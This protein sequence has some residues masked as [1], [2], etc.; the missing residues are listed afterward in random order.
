MRVALL[1]WLM[2]CAAAR[3]EQPAGSRKPLTFNLGPVVLRPSGFFD[4]IAE[5]RSATTPDTISTNFGAIPLRATPGETL[6][7]PGHS[8]L[9]LKAETGLAGGTL[10]GY[11]EADFLDKAGYQCYRSRQY[12]GEYSRSGWRVLAGQAW[13]LLR[14]NRKG[15]STESGLLNTQAVDP[16]YHVGLAGVRKPQVRITRAM[17]N[18][19]AALAYEYRQGGDVLLKL[20]RDSRLMHLEAVGLGGHHGRKGASLAAVAHAGPRVDLV[21]QQLWSQGGG[22]DVLGCLPRGVHA[23]ATI[24]GVEARV[25]PTLEVF[26]YGGLVYGTRSAGNRTVRQWSAGFRQKLFTQAGYGAAYLMGQYS[27]LDRALW[28]GPRG[29]MNFAMLAFRY[30]M[31]AQ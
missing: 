29:N 12:W 30:Y 23:H 19:A 18:W 11:F 1:L 28:S 22:P 5:Y 8:R 24:Q 7:S 2:L 17:G 13:S 3:P 21:S 15:I 27:Q 6:A 20:A 26:S 25:L 4:Y 10:A 31:P 14:P 16:A 9:S